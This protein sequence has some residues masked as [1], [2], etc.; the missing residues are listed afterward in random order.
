MPLQ[1]Q[2]SGQTLPTPLL[3]SVSKGAFPAHIWMHWQFDMAKYPKV[4]FVV[5][6]KQL[7]NPAKKIY[8][9][10]MTITKLEHTNL[11][12]QDRDVKPRTRYL[13][14]S[15][16]IRDKTASAWSNED[17]GYLKETNYPTAAILYESN[18]LYQLAW[19]PV[20]EVI[21]YRL[22][23]IAADAK[24]SYNQNP[25]TGFYNVPLLKDTV[26][27]TNQYIWTGSKSVLWSVQC[28]YPTSK[29][30]FPTPLHADSLFRYGAV[31]IEHNRYLKFPNLN[32]NQLSFLVEN[33]T[34][35]TIT[36]MQIGIY[37]SNRPTFD[38]KEAIL[39]KNRMVYL[40]PKRR[41]GFTETVKTIGF[42]YIHLVP[43]QAGQILTA[44]IETIPIF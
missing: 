41:E 29:S 35:D 1:A 26:L 37:L 8:S 21:G 18:V 11:I 40:P 9:P 28:L 7:L 10:W 17:Y 39:I 15:K 19:S 22:Q 25:I 32:Q 43:V 24:Q 36:E 23:I 38:F 42:K 12:C 30:H 5:E 14:R 2:K 31:K 16:A 34:Q 4:S 33:P 3:D 20:Q 6:R 44:E 27:T 13:Y